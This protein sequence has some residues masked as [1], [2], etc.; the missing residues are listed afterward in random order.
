M[1]VRS[2]AEILTN[3]TTLLADNT[4]GDVSLGDFRSVLTDIADSM[5]NPT[6]DTQNNG[7][8]AWDG[9]RQY[10]TNEIVWY[11]NV[12][13]KANTNPG[14][15]GVFD[16]TEWDDIPNQLYSATLNLSSTQIL[17]LFASP[18]TIVT[19]VVGKSILVVSCFAQFTHVTTPYATSSTVHVRTD[20]ADSHQ[21]MFVNTLASGANVL[22]NGIFGNAAANQNKL[23]QSAN[24]NIQAEGADPTA[25]D[26]TLSITVFYLLV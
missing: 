9:T 12:W 17:N 8:Y 10:Q 19:G 3:I 25:G 6:T 15:T 24:L 5:L 22:T 14:V 20:T 23:V 18:V 1:A 21:F 11:Q 7:L 4:S 26:S 2:R 13:Y 16:P